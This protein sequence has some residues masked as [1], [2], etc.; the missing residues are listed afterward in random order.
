MRTRAELLSPGQH[1]HAHYHVPEMSKNIA[2][3][4]NRQ[5]VAARC[6]EAAVQK[7]IEVALARIP[8]DD[9]LRKDLELSSLKTAKHHDAH[10]LSL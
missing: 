10:T 6:D 5:G 3:K 2:Y 1:P 7:T 9:E 4:A 8:Y